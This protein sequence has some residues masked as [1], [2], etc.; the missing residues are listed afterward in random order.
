MAGS[1]SSGSR[2]A[3]RGAS[4]AWPPLLD[5]G[6][7]HGGL[8]VV[9]LT[10]RAAL[11]LEGRR[12]QHCVVSYAIKCLLAESAIFSIR[13]AAG[14]PLSTFEARVPTDGQPELLRHH[15]A[16][17]VPPGEREQALAQRFVERVLARLPRQ[18]VGTVQQ[19]RRELGLRVRALLG[20][21]DTIERPLTADD[22]GRLGEAIAIAHPAEARR[23]GVVAFLKEQ[24]PAVL[25]AMG[26]G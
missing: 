2:T 5:A 4:L 12:L 17:N 3:T 18:R 22:L 6:A 25:S 15:A 19:A 8:R 7:W 16:A 23:M 20:K 13:D 1:A 24:G 9:E 14:A 26:A 11:E 21:P 10:S